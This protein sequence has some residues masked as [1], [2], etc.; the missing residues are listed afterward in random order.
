MNNQAVFSTLLRNTLSV[1]EGVHT[2]VTDFVNT[3]AALLTVSDTEIDE[4]VKHTHAANTGRASAQKVIIPAKVIIALKS[5]LFELKDRELCGA[6]PDMAFLQTIDGAQLSLMRSNR[7]KAIEIAELRNNQSHPEM[8][9]PKLTTANFEDFSLAFTGAVRRLIGVVGIP[10]DYLLRENEIG[11]YDGNWENREEKLKNCISYTGQK[12]KEDSETLYGLLV[13]YVG[14]SGTGSNIIAR[15]KH[16]KNGRKCFME[17]KRHFQTESYEENKAQ[18]AEKS[19]NNASYFGERRHFT[20]ETYYEIF[21]KAFNDLDDAGG[22]YMLSEAQKV[23]KFEGGLREER[24]I[25]YSIH[26]RRK[27]STLGEGDRTF[28]RYF[29]I[30]SASLSKHNSLANQNTNKNRQSLALQKYRLVEEEVTA[31]VDEMKRTP[32]GEKDV[33]EAAPI[34]EIKATNLITLPDPVV[35]SKQKLKYIRRSSGRI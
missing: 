23:N 32:C 1:N 33:E 19:I 30:F 16:S 21:T 13:Q 10:L 34:V 7:N 24:A 26:A 27:W 15:Y 25:N 9:V 12:F 14:T 35:I 18:A 2:T 31:P 3:Y 22:V 29:T 8:V 11:D 28:E 6:L 20:I 17:L 5:I 4:F